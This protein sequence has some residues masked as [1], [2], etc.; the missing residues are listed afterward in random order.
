VTT[1]TQL[2]VQRVSPTIGAEV[3]GVDL[4]QSLSDEVIAAIRAAWLEHLVLFFP[5]QALTPDQQVAFAQRFGEVTEG[6]P[7]EPSLEG[8]KQVLPI[9]SLK[10]RTNFWHTDVTFMARPPTG[11]LLYA[12]TLP[13]VGGDTMW[14]NTRASYDALAEPLRDML[15]GLIGIHY[16]PSY[17]EEIAKGAGQEW[18]GERVTKLWPV[19]HPL[20]RVHPETGRKNLFVNPNF[21][22]AIKDMYGLQGQGLLKMLYDHMTQYEYICRYRWRPGTLGFWDNRATMHYGIYDYG[23][24]RRVMHRVT[25]RGERPQ[26]LASIVGS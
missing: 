5:D 23:T 24:E 22:V 18:E 17:A 11:S 6:H 7:V 8:Y 21:T 15:D 19:E 9:D 20:V 1:T 12:V 14:A 3:R 13:E 10:D 16:D 4:S 2:D 26:G 25:L